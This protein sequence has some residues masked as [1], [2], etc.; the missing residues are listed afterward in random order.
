MDQFFTPAALARQV[1]ARAKVA[2]QRVLE[3]SAGHGALAFEAVLQG[4]ERVCCV[5]LDP[6]CRA[7][8]CRQA[9]TKIPQASK[10]V[11]LRENN[12]LTLPPLSVDRVVM[13]PPFS[14]QKDVLH[15]EA[16]FG[17]LTQNGLLVAVMAAGIT[18]RQDK[19]SKTFRAR[20][21]ACGGSIEPLPDDSF[22]ETGTG[23]RTVLVTMKKASKET[24]NLLATTKGEKP[25]R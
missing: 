3:P 19:R 5:E 2:G 14:R 4:A 7:E 21:A 20:V 8:L 16:A 25:C 1:V 11:F 22:R 10:L 13:N 9:L 24:T 18:F 6:A 12:F 15:V 17:R 23:V